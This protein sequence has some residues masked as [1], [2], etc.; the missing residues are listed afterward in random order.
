M[1]RSGKL[2]GIKRCMEAAS[3]SGA[4]R[5]ALLLDKDVPYSL[6]SVTEAS[7]EDAKASGLEIH[8]VPYS[9][10]LIVEQSNL[11]MLDTIIKMKNGQD[12]D[13]AEDKDRVQ[14]IIDALQEKV[15]EEQEDVCRPGM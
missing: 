3:S 15:N 4:A 12:S 1:I 2:S 14:Q 10:Q 8:P 9:E 13:M 11:D 5:G 7:Q 6:V